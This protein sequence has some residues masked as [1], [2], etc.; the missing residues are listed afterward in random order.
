MREVIGDTEGCYIA[1][2]DPESFAEGIRKALAF[3]KRT[4]GRE[5]IMHLDSN[6]IAQKI[7]A[8]YNEILEK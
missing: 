3:G 7:I 2:S 8:L 6:I 1:G 5:K 4:S